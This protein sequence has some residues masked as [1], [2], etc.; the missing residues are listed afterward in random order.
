LERKKERSSSRSGLTEKM[1]S[2]I[3][4]KLDEDALKK[5]E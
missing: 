4:K 5:E 1:Q 2:S 3:Q